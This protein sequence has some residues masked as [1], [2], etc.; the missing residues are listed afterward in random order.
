MFEKIRLRR[1]RGERGAVAV[2]FAI[3]LPLLIVMLFAIIAFGIALF[4]LITYV[5]A[6]RE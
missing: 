1:L 4:R 3:I 2:E 5:G 6:A